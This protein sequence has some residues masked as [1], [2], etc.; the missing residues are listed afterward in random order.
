MVLIRREIS[1]PTI[2]LW[3][4][5]PHNEDMSNAVTALK[6]TAAATFATMTTPNLI[7]MMV[8]NTGTDATDR[9]VSAWIA[10]E[11][12]SRYDVAEAM[13]AWADDIDT[14][15]TYTEALIAA[16]PAEAVA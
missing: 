1:G 15:M 6:N 16:L 9:M 13:D 3:L 4:C 11:V 14:E 2:D 10:E 7:A 5:V 12:E 8:A